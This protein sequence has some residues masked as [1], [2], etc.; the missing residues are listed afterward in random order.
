MLTS[1]WL[2]ILSSIHIWF[3][4]WVKIKLTFAGHKNGA[5]FLGAVIW[6]RNDLYSGMSF[7][8]E[9]SSYCIHMVK[10]KGSALRRSGSLSL[11]FAL[12]Q[13]LM[14]HPPQTRKPEWLR[15]TGKKKIPL[16]ITWTDANKGRWN[17]LDLEWNCFRYQVKGKGAHEP[18]AQTARAYRGFLSTKHA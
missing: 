6:Y 11:I 14:R 9:R 5:C 10:S 4:C 8:P 7:V 1:Y 17:E 18:K 3:Q 15:S 16:G 13:I 12:D 2:S